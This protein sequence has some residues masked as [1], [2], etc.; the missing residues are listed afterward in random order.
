VS[1]RELITDGVVIAVVYGI[2]KVVEL[3]WNNRKTGA[4]T[5]NIES[6]GDLAQAQAFAILR[7]QVNDMEAKI[8]ALRGRVDALEEQLEIKEETIKQKDSDIEKLQK[9]VNKLDGRLS[10]VLIYLSGLLEELNSRGIQYTP[11]EPGVLDTDPRIP[12][13]RGKK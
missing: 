6:Q 3:L 8:I 11:P 2:F 4:E 7:T 9:Q 5:D 10:K 1:W 12:A 13:V